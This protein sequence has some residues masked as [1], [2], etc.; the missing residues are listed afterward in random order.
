M[1]SHATNSLLD[2]QLIG[3]IT[4][5]GLTLPMQ[6]KADDA[7]TSHI[8]RV[9]AC[10]CHRCLGGQAPRTD[11]IYHSQMPYTHALISNR[12]AVVN[13]SRSPSKH[14]HSRYA[15]LLP[16]SISEA[17]LSTQV[18][19]QQFKHVLPLLQYSLS[20]SQAVYSGCLLRSI[21][22]SSNRRE[23]CKRPEPFPW[24]AGMIGCSAQRKQL[25][26]VHV[27]K[28]TTAACAQSQIAPVKGSRSR[29]AA[30]HKQ[31]MH[32]KMHVPEAEECNI[33][34]N[35]CASQAI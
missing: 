20:R 13:R 19:Q 22:S 26:H 9:V 18:E 25:M 10:R 7:T 4:S 14:V 11:H 27:S 8:A 2:R 24:T 31:Q 3:K 30:Q 6:Y 5:S 1:S 33:H 28:V 17:V 32:V 29:H 16:V 35:S 23:R 12:T 21:S 15:L 34:T